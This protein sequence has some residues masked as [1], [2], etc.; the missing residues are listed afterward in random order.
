MGNV[1]RILCISSIDWHFIWQRHQ[2]FMKGFADQGWE[3][4]Y[5]GNTFFR[6]PKWSDL[7]RLRNKT[8]ASS[9]QN[10]IPSNVKL[11]S[12]QVLPPNGMLFRMLNRYILIPRLLRKLRN[13]YDIVV[14]Y[15]PSYTTEIILSKI[16][17]SWTIFDYVAHFEGHPDCSK[18]YPEIESRIMAQTDMVTT[19]STFLYEL[20][21]NRHK[22][23]HQIHH[24]VQIEHFIRPTL[25]TP[26][27]AYR[28]FCFFGG[29]D[30]RMDW[31]SI[32]AI[33][34]AGYEVTL[35]GPAKVR[36]PNYVIYKPAMNMEELARE[37]D[38]YNAFIIPYLLTD[39]NHGI[40]PAKI[41]ECFAMGKPLLVSPL[42]ALESL[43]KLLYICR[44][45]ED[46]VRTIA[47]LNE[48]ESMSIISK[49]KE[50]ALD[51]S[52]GRNFEKLLTIIKNERGNDEKEAVARN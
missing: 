52:T 10:D 2:T 3:V 5:L 16:S 21:R 13:H 34:M 17:K 46:Y 14:L 19:D 29:I 15:M 42:P 25:N 9:M 12:P 43:N 4:D 40:I 39:Y 35:I 31:D 23:V 33:A 30:D 48:T 24:G 49:R 27:D 1:R 6:N 32:K 41:Y 18:D 50:L 26:P 38:K 37:L 11:I 51:Q 22:S 8:K 7:Y 45:P 47:G 28:K 44:T 36:V 20:L